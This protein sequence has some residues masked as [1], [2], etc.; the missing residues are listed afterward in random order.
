LWVDFLAP[1]CA[2]MASVCLCVTHCALV[3]LMGA[4][5]RGDLVR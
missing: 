5:N 1:L 4:L 2:K 3:V